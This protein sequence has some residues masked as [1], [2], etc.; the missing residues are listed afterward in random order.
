MGKNKLEEEGKLFMKN[1]FA[2][3]PRSSRTTRTLGFGLALLLGGVSIASY[4]KGT[5]SVVRNT[6]KKSSF[7]QASAKLS[8]A[9][10]NEAVGKLPLAF[11][12]NQGQTDQQVNY[13]ARAKGYTAFLTESETVLAI[14]GSAQG[15]LRMKMQNAT[16][17]ARVEGSDPQAGKSNYLRPSGNITNVPN[18]GKVTYKG[19]YP[20]IDVAY[21]G[22]QR[23]LEYDF[24]VSP[25]ADTNQIRIAYEGSSRF[26]L[27][28]EGDL[29]LETAAGRTLAR[30]PVSYQT[31]HGARKAVQ[32]EYVLMAGNQVSFKLGA[33]DRSK[34]LIIDPTLAVLAMVGG[35]GNDEAFAMAANASGVYLTGR[36]V[37]LD[38]LVLSALQS[39]H[40]AGPGNNFDVFITKLDPTG[41][42]LVFSTY[43]GAVG[44]DAAE[45]IA[46]DTAGNAYIGGY[47]NLALT[48]APAPV[49]A[50]SGV[51]SAFVAKVAPS[52]TS[53]V[54]LTYLGG[55]GT[56]QAFS[57]AM[58]P[59]SG[60]LVIGG[61]TTGLPGTPSGQNKTFSG[62]TSDGFIAKFDANLYLTAST[63]LGGSGY[64]QVNSVAVD[65]SG[66]VYAAGI[67][68]S[69]N[70][71][72][73][74]GYIPF[75][76]TTSA[77]TGIQVTGTVPLGQQTA[78]V[79]KYN[80]ALTTRS[81]SSIF[82]AG[83]ETANGVAAD[84][85]GNAYVVGATRSI[86]FDPY[87]N[88]NDG[89]VAA[90]NGSLPGT[91]PVFGAPVPA[92][93][94]GGVAFNANPSPTQGYLLTVSSV[95]QIKSL[96]FQ[97]ASAAI[98]ATTSCNLNLPRFGGALGVP[99]PCVGRTGGWNAVAVD[100]DMQA[101]V[102]GQQVPGAVYI[103]DVVR[104]RTSTLAGTPQVT[105]FTG[106]AGADNQ[107][108]GIAVN[109]FREAFF[110]GITT[111]ASI[112]AITSTLAPGQIGIIGPKTT[113]PPPTAI[114]NGAGT[115]L[116]PRTTIANNGGEDVL[117]GAIQYSDI[118]VTPPTLNMG[119]VAVGSGTGSAGPT[120][121]V[122][123]FN[124][125]GIAQPCVGGTVNGAALP[126]PTTSGSFTITQIAN[127]NTFQ[128]QLAAG[129]TATPQVLGPS[130]FVF[131]C[132]GAENLSTVT[133]TG[134][135]SGIV[136]PPT[137]T[138]LSPNSSS[139]GA[140]TL[141]MTVNGTNFVGPVTVGQQQIPG[142]QV[143]WT[144]GNVVTPLA[145]TFVSSNQLA[146]VVPS[147]LLAA[148]GSAAVT[149]AQ[150]GNAT[151]NE[152]PF[153]VLGPSIATIVPASVPAGSNAITLTV[154]GANFV[155]NAAQSAL[156]TVSLNGVALITTFVNSGTLTAAVPANLL[157]S[158]TVYSVQVANP[159]GAV[160]GT[161][162]FS[163]IALAPVISA[164][165]PTSVPAGS[166][167]FVLTVTG[168]NYL[169]GAQVSFG[170]TTLSA[171]LV[172]STTLTTT[173]PANLVA[174][175]G[176]VNVQVV[177]PGGTLSNSVPFTV[178]AGPTL[179]TISPTTVP[180]GSATFT[181]IVAGTNFV[182][183]SQVS[184]NGAA[185]A[186]TF[187]SSTGLTAVVPA[188]LVTT[189]GQ[190]NAQVINPDGPP[191]N[192]LPFNVA[193][194]AISALSPATVV[195]GSAAFNLA[196]N[197]VNFL[198]GSQ[199]SFDGSALTTS[200]VSSAALTAT[201][202]AAL[203]A[204]PKVAS[205]V[206]T[207]PGGS[208]SSAASFTV[209]PAPLAITTTSLPSGTSGSSYSF[210]LAGR[211]GT[212]PYT[213]SASGLPSSLFVNPATGVISGVLQASGTFPITVG[214]RDAAGATATAQFQLVVSL[215]PVSIAPSSNLPS[216]VVGVAYLGF[217]FANGGTEQ[218]TFS[219]GSGSLPDG[220]T[221]SSGGMISGTPKTPGQF[222][223]SVV[224]RDSA[225]AT[226]S[227]GFQIAIQPAPLN[228]T[229]GPTTPTVPAGT[230]ISISF[231]GTGGVGPYRFTLCSGVPPGTTFSDGVLSGTPTTPGAFNVCVTVADSTGAVFTKNVTL[232]VVPAALSLSGS[233]PDG[234]V[235]VPYKAQISAAGGTGPYSYAGSGLPDGLSLSA[236]GSISG[237]PGT[238][239]QF[240]FTATATD[241]TGAK[242][243]GTFRI[244]IVPAD[245][246]IVTASL[247]DGVVGVAYSASLTASGGVPPYKWTVT[248]LPDGVT[249]TAAGAISGTPTKA[250]SF[251]VIVSVTDAAGTSIAPARRPSPVTIAPAP[252]VITTATAPNGTAGTAYSASFAASGGTAPLTF[253]ATGLPAGL[254]MSA[255][256]TITGTPTAPG[257]ATIVVTVKDAAGASAS[258]SFPVTIGLP[259][260]P[261][262]NFAGVSDTALPLQQPRLQVTL[263]NSFPVDVVV[264]LT[265]SFAPDSGADDPTIQ[266]SGGGR[267]ARITVPA[268]ATTGST[269]IGVQTGS[270]AGLIAITAQMQ[271]T[272]QD[273]TP[274]PA[275]RRTIRVAAAA[276][277]IVPGTL[278]AVRNS[279]GFT[280]T[281]TGYVTDREL[282]QAVF[283]FTAA[284]GSNLQ[285]TTLTVP[286]DALFVQYFSGS[287]ATPF[288]SQFT[289]TQPFTVTGSTQAIVS[290]TVTLVNKI[291][292]SAP[293]TATLN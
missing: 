293:A 173:V 129:A 221:L 265:L 28:A 233:L 219:L 182:S 167:A 31:I 216:G 249:A 130:T 226:A 123:L 271:A 47:T 157:T 195:A 261:P 273:V 170:G 86:Y 175:P 15:V 253:S 134:A 256:G 234:K 206:V 46:L 65:S 217:V 29:E 229:G 44:D 227:Q 275:P 248:G 104:A 59:S 181:L 180:A 120:Q 132:P 41:S 251:T 246:S 8:Q 19:I 156:S 247:P 127:T 91:A 159:G 111:S 188:N 63:Y 178:V 118:Y 3:T 183:R 55:N 115:T 4:S 125:L 281:L 57:L 89:T 263:G 67:T 150:P 95:G 232:T 38:F 76:T 10:V 108:F 165:S 94:V 18:Y 133:V 102:T 199:V 71:T 7:V 138:S 153:S 268:G 62:G 34:V 149:V 5:K 240:S 272:G 283:V 230:P 189:A 1:L 142:S 42:T 96:A 155:V 244:T 139:A 77:T 197:G 70:G 27:N 74:A 49:V 72:A 209:T 242:A 13:V 81:H 53:V 25:G 58:D 192:T 124:Q 291:G 187:G 163:V 128:I 158:P 287:G 84:S 107:G 224:V 136:N 135:V 237:T 97:T 168:V 64:D 223:F 282:T 52:G 289:Y 164:I 286:A 122:S 60:S 30:K 241:S 218:Y 35:T 208:V 32:S 22:S 40:S 109:S 161:V 277:V 79:T 101:Y 6:E 169:S 211:G 198:P 85:N 116:D 117:Y 26:A 239:G 243:N 201:V 177:N 113:P 48:P 174:T 83:G 56:T 9:K 24:V 269:D 213:W 99:S 69:G 160:S 285:T 92:T 172:N 266:F 292:Q 61:L 33:Y 93:V 14:K 98:A 207:N 202:P 16:P 215:P 80:A 12:P 21:Y 36:T 152:L 258:K 112:A 151:S 140:A 290:V 210:T 137:L 103:A 75:P 200:F 51:Y 214:L 171:T 88:N 203:I 222:S 121:I 220:L 68:A 73:G 90:V 110:D 100:S 274:S 54:A 147:A 193:R 11:E 204:G 45:G 176:Q 235:G 82:G 276:P 231:T 267:T 179:S 39:T 87:G 212:P 144:A 262:L 264:T 252:L 66:N 255:A 245:L 238:A 184:F 43:L 20:G 37:S 278:T 185:L 143:Q 196:V 2:N 259:P 186:T 146:A 105:T 194:P 254:S 154:N 166:S 148:A 78:F 114:I 106:A 145:T 23:T 228:F 225:G 236:S 191:S 162:P 279:T 270:V 190:V 17:T 288:G 205:I 119:T 131:S 50:F 257:A 260:A 126:G 141:T 250:G 284:S 280:V